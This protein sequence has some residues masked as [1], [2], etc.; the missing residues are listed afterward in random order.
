MKDDVYNPDIESQL[1]SPQFD[2]NL[3]SSNP[4]A[5]EAIME[6]LALQQE[7]EKQYAAKK[8]ENLIHNMNEKKIATTID[9]EPIQDSS[10]KE[11]KSARTV[12]YPQIKPAEEL[13]DYK[14]EEIKQPPFIPSK[15]SSIKQRIQEAEAR[16]GIDHSFSAVKSRSEQARSFFDEFG[17]E[18]F[19]VKN[20]SNGIVVISDLDR[21]QNGISGENRIPR[22]AVI[23][24]L[25]QYD[26]ETLRK[27]RELRTAISGRGSQLLLK[28]LTPEE[29]LEEIEREAQNKE[30]I[31][32]FKVMAELKAS[33]GQSKPKK[34]IRPVIESKLLQLQLSY[35]DTPH[36]GITPVEF[37]QWLNTEKLTLDELDYILSGV[38]DKDIR[39]FVHA[40]KQDLL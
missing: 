6:K 29:Y 40:K 10:S 34:P 28:R 32:Q 5:P 27:S 39:M 31:E 26:L 38:D 19:Y 2:R 16:L 25:S 30:K 33:T 17:E 23:D 8:M 7:A 21:G 11:L 1:G 15:S 36:K 37:I 22:G 12:N 35:S 18:T 9:S 4:I 14:E 20:I 3:M 24:L 13:V